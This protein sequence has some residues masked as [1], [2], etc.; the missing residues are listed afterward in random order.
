MDATGQRPPNRMKR[1]LA[2]GKVSLGA[3]ITIASPAITE[4]LSRVGL[5]W[6]WI[7]TEH[8]AITL[9]DA[10]AMLQV[11]NG[12]NVSTV[13]RVPWNDKTLIK[14]ALD[15]GPDAILVPLINTAEEAEAAVQAMKY[16]PAGERGAGLGRAQA[17]GM[18]MGPYLQTANDE[19][20]FIAQ[21]E[22][23]TA[24]EHID[25]IVGVKGLD[26]AF[27]GALDLSGSMGK[28]GQTDDPEVEEAVQKVLASCKAAG[29][30]CGIVA[31]APEVAN[32]RIE[33]GFT[34]L[35]VAIDVLL[36]H[37]GASATL[38]QIN[39]PS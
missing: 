24:I 30:P 18:Q 19:V 5:D 32:Q 9:A 16:P 2:A 29:V 8:T 37:G 7:D 3:T 38:S 10:V 1:D 26:A 4:M 27:V 34:F 23:V 22:H 13:I 12:S 20:M 6:L 39:R 11:T 28:L 25:E 15:I 36:V 17:Y 14:R 31:L 35:I 33:Q 21:I